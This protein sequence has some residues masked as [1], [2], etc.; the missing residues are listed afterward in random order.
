[1][2]HFFHQR[3]HPSTAVHLKRTIDFV[4]CI[5]ILIFG[6]RQQICIKIED[7][8]TEIRLSLK[9]T[10]FF[11]KISINQLIHDHNY[12]INKVLILC[13]GFRKCE[14][15]DTKKEPFRCPSSC[16]SITTSLFC[17]MIILIGS[18]L[19]EHYFSI[20]TLSILSLSWKF[21][22]PKFSEDA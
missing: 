15:N 19:L 12:S 13:F 22:V 5:G 8:D 9:L 6:N 10:S 16:Y 7:P 20:E 3:A 17:Y 18:F 11:L 4:L 21:D 14:K 1:M 2:L